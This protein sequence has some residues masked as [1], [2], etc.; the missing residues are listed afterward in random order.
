[1]YL[2]TFLIPKLVRNE[3]KK[4]I[5]NNSLSCKFP[6]LSIHQFLVITR[7]GLDPQQLNPIPYPDFWDLDLGYIGYQ[8]NIHYKSGIFYLQSVKKKTV[9]P[10]LYKLY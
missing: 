1:M 10:F 5:L 6:S 4:S 7:D 3:M 8:T 2:T 9:L